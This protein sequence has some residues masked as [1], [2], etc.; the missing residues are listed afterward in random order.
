MSSRIG[1]ICD[2]CGTNSWAYPGG[3]ARKK[4]GGEWKDLCPRCFDRD[5]IIRATLTFPVD[6]TAKKIL[7]GWK[8]GG[9][10]GFNLYNGFGGKVEDGEKILEAAVRELNEEAGVKIDKDQ[11]T[12]SGRLMFRFPF[13]RVYPDMDVYVF[14]YFDFDVGGASKGFD[15]YGRGPLFVETE[16]M[17]P[18]LFGLDR[19]PYDKMWRDDP[20]WLP[21][22]LHHRFVEG[23]FRFGDDDDYLDEVH[24]R[25]LDSFQELNNRDIQEVYPDEED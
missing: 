4:I 24:L 25:T 9:G 1:L 2:S 7:L 19:I 17:I 12:W 14:C 13:D 21:E 5:K 10:V 8:K 3:W 16:E 22:V 15:L 23:H 20:V 18:K 11:L 6:L